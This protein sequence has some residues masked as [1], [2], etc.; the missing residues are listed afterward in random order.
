VIN[1]IINA[2]DDLVLQARQAQQLWQTVPLARRAKLLLAIEQELINNSDYWALQLT[3]ETRKPLRESYQ[4]ELTAA[5]G[6]VSY[7]ARHGPSIL[8][9]RIQTP[10]KSW[11]LGRVHTRTYRPYGV[12]GLITP[13]NFPLAISISG[14]SVALMAGNAV[15]LKPSDYTPIL[16]QSLVNCLQTILKNQGLPVTLVQC[17]LGGAEAGKALVA[18]PGVNHIIF[19][20]SVATGKAVQSSTLARG[21]S[22]NLELGGQDAMLVLPNTNGNIDA[23]DSVISYAVW[24][25]FANAGQTCAAIKRLMVPQQHLPLVLQALKTKVSQLVVGDPLSPQTHMGPLIHPN[26]KQIIAEQVKD[27]LAHG[28]NLICGGTELTP[29]N[30]NQHDAYYAPT[31][32]VANDGNAP[33]HSRLWTEEVFGPVLLVLGYHNVKQALDWINDSPFGLTASVFGPSKQAK[34]IAQQLSVGIVTLC[35]TGAPQYALPSVAWLGHKH[36]GSGV[37]HG[38]DGLLACAKLTT[39]TQ[40]W[41]FYCPWFRKSPWLYHKHADTVVPNLDFAK[42]LPITFGPE[43]WLCK[44]NPFF[45]IGVWQHRSSTRL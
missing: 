15:I 18:H 19:T 41:L 40:N 26:V 23:L 14:L 27:G 25:R 22:V 43:G 9:S 30:T 34:D 44:W 21:I 2:L 8:A 7:Y 16:A 42:R 17:L 33:I 35:D 20:G 4:A 13:F 32:M 1:P 3:T 10:D 12:V 24:G 5:I 11:L 28:V 6:V 45:W 31:V 39:I 38:K 37:S 36:S 29:P